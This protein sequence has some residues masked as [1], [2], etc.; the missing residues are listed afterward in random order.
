MMGTHIDIGS[1]SSTI[2]ISIACESCNA[3]KTQL[4][5]GYTCGTNPDITRSSELTPSMVVTPPENKQTEGGRDLLKA[6]TTM[7][8]KWIIKSLFYFCGC[9]TAS[10]DEDIFQGE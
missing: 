9:F 6:R 10:L 5:L 8:M 7:R 4:T 1:V 2:N 3:S